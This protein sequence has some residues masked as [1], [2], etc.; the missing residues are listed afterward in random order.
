MFPRRQRRLIAW[1]ASLA[2]LLNALVPTVAHALTFWAGIPPLVIE[3]C[4]T[5]G[6]KLIKL[7]QL[8]GSK[9]TKNQATSKTGQSDNSKAKS[10][11]HCPYCLTHSGSF[12]LPVD[13]SASTL[14]V[15][16]RNA[17]Y[18]SL[19]YRSHSP[20]FAWAIANPRAPPTHS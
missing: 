18:P 13:A 12:G 9:A 19:F 16:A 17:D 15:P 1:I 11:E 8:D 5:E 14:V 2:I 3:V 7:D 4:S 10:G 20:L 6:R